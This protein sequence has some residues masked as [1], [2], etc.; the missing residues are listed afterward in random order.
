MC[1]LFLGGGGQAA[2][3]QHPAQGQLYHRGRT[4]SVG[5]LI[6]SS[7]LLILTRNKYLYPMCKKG[8]GYLIHNPDTISILNCTFDRPCFF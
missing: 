2:Q 6:S 3:E 7:V 8:N 4:G 1:V 5:L